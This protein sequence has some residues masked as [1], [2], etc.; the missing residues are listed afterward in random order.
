VQMEHCA[1]AS[2]V[3][4]SNITHT[5]I[6]RRHFFIRVQKYSL[7]RNPTS[8]KKSAPRLSGGTD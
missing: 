3:K 6:I 2:V 1:D 4:I 5:A 8:K 7:I